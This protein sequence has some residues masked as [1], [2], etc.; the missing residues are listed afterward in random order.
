MRTYLWLPR[1]PHL[2]QVRNEK[3]RRFLSQMRPKE[4]IPFA[5]KFPK[6]HPAALKL[7]QRLLAFDP[8]LRPTAEE[9]LEDP[10]L[11]G[12]HNPAREPVA[13][14]VSKMEFEFERRKLSVE[15]VRDLIYRE[16]L[17]Y[18]P[19]A[20]REYYSGESPS[21]FQFP[22]AVDNFKRQFAHLEGGGARDLRRQA[23]SLPREQMARGTLRGKEP[24][25]A[26]PLSPRLSLVTETETAPPVLTP[27][28]LSNPASLSSQ[29]T[30]TYRHES[31]KHHLV[32]ADTMQSG[33]HS[34]PGGPS[35]MN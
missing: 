5:K 9:A 15:E 18:H 13:E 27:S 1:P 16:A 24:T 20:K 23:N 34:E 6:A 28:R 17:E 10:Y 4:P 11:T 31:G 7:L 2:A 14:P 35:P 26:A 29:E 25:H 33:H 22:S 8:A 12:L 30:N 21:R 19:Q 32:H 3:A